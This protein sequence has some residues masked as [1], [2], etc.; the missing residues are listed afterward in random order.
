MRLR[1]LLLLSGFL[2]ASAFIS[3]S[4]DSQS[5]LGL[6]HATEHAVSK[7]D[8]AKIAAEKSGGQVLSVETKEAD[9]Q[10]THFV[11]VLQADGHI[12]IIPVSAR[13][14]AVGK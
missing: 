11:K 1:N 13:D 6:A 2:L 10:T 12:K 7:D 5:V 8:A 14:G 9:G 3:Q 4:N